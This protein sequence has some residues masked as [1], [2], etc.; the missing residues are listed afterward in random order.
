MTTSRYDCDHPGCGRGGATGHAIH[1]TS[2]K[3]ELFSG[4]CE[5][6]LDRPVDPEVAVITDPIE[7]R[8]QA[9]R[10]E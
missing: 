7:D 3:G 6:H 5:E 8:N 9:V 4:S 1:R 2:P 10:D